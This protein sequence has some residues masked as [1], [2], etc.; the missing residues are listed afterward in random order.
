[1]PFS[2]LPAT[3]AHPSRFLINSE[4][5]LKPSLDSPA[6]NDLPAPKNLK[7]SPSATPAISEAVWQCMGGIFTARTLVTS[8]QCPL[9]TV[10]SSCFSHASLPD[11]NS[12]SSIF[13]EQG[14]QYLSVDRLID[15]ST[16]EWESQPDVIARKCK[17]DQMPWNEVL[18]SLL[19]NLV[20]CKTFCHLSIDG[21]HLRRDPESA[22]CC[23][24]THSKQ[25]GTL[26]WTAG[27]VHRTQ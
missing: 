27:E 22:T 16:C 24:N 20:K 15:L 19:R 1:M 14:A 7:T 23:V 8:K 9:T 12:C 6:L 11:I 25:H 4:S 5:L 10:W 2:L 26:V 3:A 17:Q 18:Y 21:K 13:H